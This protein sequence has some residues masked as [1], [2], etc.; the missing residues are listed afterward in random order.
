MSDPCFPSCGCNPTASEASRERAHRNVMSIVADE[1]LQHEWNTSG[2]VSAPER[3]SWEGL[4]ECYKT[5]GR[6]WVHRLRREVDESTTE[7][8]YPVEL[9]FWKLRSEERRVGKECRSRW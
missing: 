7:W 9:E 6:H 1:L 2:S 4:M 5:E 3:Y 8:D